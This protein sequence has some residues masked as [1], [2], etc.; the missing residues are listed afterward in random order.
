MQNLLHFLVLFLVP[1][2]AFSQYQTKNYNDYEKQ[3]GHFQENDS[4]A[5]MPLKQSIKVAK[6]RKDYR[7]LTYV[8]EDAIYF[9]KDREAKLQYAD[10]SLMAAKHLKDQSLLANAYLGK[11]I[12]YYYNFRD[13]HNALAQYLKAHR[14]AKKSKDI[15]LKYKTQF[16]VGMVKKYFG[17]YKEADLHFAECVAYFKQ[18]LKCAA[19]HPTLIYNMTKGYLNALHQQSLVKQN[20]KEYSASSDLISEGLHYLRDLDGFSEE[21]G[22]FKLSRGINLLFAKDF[23]NSYVDLS[24]A[25]FILKYEQDFTSLALTHYYLGNVSIQRKD[26]E[27]AKKHF[28]VVDSLYSKYS[29]YEPEL[30]Y[31]YRH[32]IKSLES[33]EDVKPMLCYFDQLLTIDSLASRKTAYMASATLQEFN[34]ATEL[35]SNQKSTI[36][37]QDRTTEQLIIILIGG[38]VFLFLYMQ[39]KNFYLQRSLKIHFLRFRRRTRAL[40]KPFNANDIRSAIGALDQF[41]KELGFVK[42]G[43]KLENV[44]TQL[45]LPSRL[46]SYVINTTKKENFNSYLNRLRVE[47]A[48]KQIRET[49]IFTELSV[50][51]IAQEVGFSSRQ[52]FSR[53]FQ[54]VFGATPREYSE[55]MEADRKSPS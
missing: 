42:K 37:A 49:S 7:H 16:H 13:Y 48:A 31:N 15:Y 27:N 53:L 24:D 54:Q 36:S 1:V 21:R 9:V 38:A 6:T 44:A 3:Y 29:F 41:E 35:T 12:V 23:Q 52:A 10:S 19:L 20:L 30:R 43:I 8:Y 50:Q 46:L 28:L 11:G 39:P 51:G 55:R 25:L 47:Y 34:L 33:K 17:F 14:A 26:T 5:L 4:R 45:K 40:D 22:K 2:S 18:Q 32:L